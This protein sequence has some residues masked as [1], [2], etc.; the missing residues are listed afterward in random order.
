MVSTPFKYLTATRIFWAFLLIALLPWLYLRSQQA[1]QS[2]MLWLTEALQRVLAGGKMSEVAYETNPPLSLVIYILPVLAK[3]FLPIPLHY[4]AFAQ[5]LILTI[6]STFAVH[7]IITAWKVFQAAE[8]NIMTAAYL[9]AVT[10]MVS[11]YYGERD[12]LLALGLVPFVLLQ[13]SLT[14]KLPR[15]KGWTMPVL[16]VGAIVI[17]LKPHHGLLPTIMLAHRAIT[18]R[19]LSVVFDADFL[20][21]AL[22]VLSYLA[23][24]FLVFPDYAFVVFPDVVNLYLKIGKLDYVFAGLAFFIVP[25][26]VLFT[27]PPFLK[28]PQRENYMVIFLTACALI[29]TIPFVVQKIGFFYHLAPAMAFM[30]MPI[31]LTLFY[32]LNLEIK[33][34]PL[35]SLTTLVC[36][37]WITAIS[38]PKDIPYPDHRFFAE[39]PFARLIGTC[40]NPPCSYFMFNSEMGIMHETSYYTGIPHVS[41]FPSLWFLPA[42]IQTQKNL[43]AG[44]SGPLTAEELDIYYNRFATMLA[45]DLDR[46]QPFHVVIWDWEDSGPG[47]GFIEYFERNPAFRDAMK[48]YKKT[49]D[50]TLNYSDFY[51]ATMKKQSDQFYTLYERQELQSGI[52]SGN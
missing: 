19:R 22:A 7:K 35:C 33:K 32:A 46:A 8:I 9:L 43:D 28:M 38:A 2:D 4:A 26:I 50:L 5:T 10:V 48:P 17:L 14:F 41:R 1:T 49:G 23:L 20:S 30:A 52:K 25:S 39:T 16:A 45:E 18:Q 47:M 15:P 12:H 51:M 21:L 44:E 37:L 29:A 36:L 11:I 6:F 42:M 31:A 24:I 27:L 3:S 13:V 40:P 34:P